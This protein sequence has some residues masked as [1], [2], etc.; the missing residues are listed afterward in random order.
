[1]RR[2]SFSRPTLAE[3]V[4]SGRFVLTTSL[5]TLAKADEGLLRRRLKHIR[6][7]FGF[8]KFGDNPR[9]RARVSPWA[10]AAVAI[11][12]GVEPIVHVGCRDRNR[13]AIQADL[14]GGRLLGVHS[15][16]CLRGDEIG[17]SDQPDARAVHDLDVVDLVRLASRDEAFF[18]L[19]A[20]DPAA[21]ITE[22]HLQR[23]QAKLNAGAA[24]L[25][26]QPVFSGARFTAWLRRARDAGME[27]PVLVDVS[28]AATPGEAELLERI[29]HVQP[30][31]GLAERVRRDPRAGI[32]LAAEVVAE[33][34]DT[35]GVIGC[36]VS[37]LGGDPASALAV[38]DRLR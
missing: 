21:P 13:L 36:H 32:A 33:V 35:P 8:V 4:A 11:G 26:T 25:E 27:A 1:M 23:L 15:V 18:V 9:A 20:C 34:R 3:A 2:D 29:P 16:L 7:A 17:V 19:A 5:G 24:V 22:A 12:E 28:V 14:L 30:P 10:A 38:L 37:P 31:A 6:E